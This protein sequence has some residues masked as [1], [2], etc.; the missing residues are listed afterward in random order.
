MEVERVAL[1]PLATVGVV[2][3]THVPD[4]VQGLHPA[5]L[6][7]LKAAGVDL[8]LHAGDISKPEVLHALEDIAPV[9]AAGGNRDFIFLRRLPGVVHLEVAGAPIVLMHGHGN[10]LRYLWIKFNYLINGYRLEQ[11][12]SLIQTSSPQSRVVVFGHSHIPENIDLNGRLV[13]NPGSAGIGWRNKVPPSYGILRFYPDSKVVGEVI[14][15][16][17]ARICKRMWQLLDQ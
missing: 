7:G 2:A 17:G 10:F 1:T 14:E 3:D 6:P 15:L 8:I 12:L 16:T 11:Y 5:L 4:R 13:F 9:T